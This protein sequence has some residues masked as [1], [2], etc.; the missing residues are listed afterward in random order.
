MPDSR[1]PSI[2]HIN[3]T[4]RLNLVPK[5]VLVFGALVLGS[6]IHH[7]RLVDAYLK[8]K[9]ALCVAELVL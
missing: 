1:E 6:G 8:I 2:V 9:V 4:M 5:N 7:Y 3:T